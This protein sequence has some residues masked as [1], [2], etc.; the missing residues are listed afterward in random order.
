MNWDTTE[1]LGGRQKAVEGD[2]R[3]W[4]H[5]L[6]AVIGAVIVPVQRGAPVTAYRRR[7]L[8]A[9]PIKSHSAGV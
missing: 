2:G 5:L 6:K 7:A 4:S 3:S 1:R 9:C 8:Y